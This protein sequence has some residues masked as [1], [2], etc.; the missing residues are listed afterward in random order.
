MD[1]LDV[2]DGCD[3]PSVAALEIFAQ[4]FKVCHPAY[5]KDDLECFSMWRYIGSDREQAARLKDL[6]MP[7]YTSVDFF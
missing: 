6:S 2:R 3:A 1:D 7:C 4:N 5:S